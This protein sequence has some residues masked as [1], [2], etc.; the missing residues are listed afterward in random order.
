VSI[1]I[2]RLPAD[3]LPRFAEIDR[4]EEVRVH[5]R[6]LR[7]QLIEEPVSEWVPDFFK[8]GDSHS[9]PELL[10]TWQ[11]VVDAGGALVGAFDA[12]RLAGLA[13][14]GTQLAPGILQV[15]ALYVSRPYRRRGIA[16]SLMAEMERLAAD[17]GARALY[18][19]AVPSESAVGFYLSHGFRPTEP[20]PAPFA[21]EPEDIHM[22]LQIS[23]SSL[24]KL[25]D[26]DPSPA[27]PV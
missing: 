23:P 21:K 8:E 12:D 6:Q 11:P 7:E 27:H 2:R 18:V 13:L 3:G 22:L 1:A 26:P 4:S 9:I 24:P 14:L 25:S 16:G 17:L 20:L 15:A 5:Y 19:S 10:K